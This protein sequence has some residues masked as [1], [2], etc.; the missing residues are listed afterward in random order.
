MALS[1]SIIRL[2][3]LDRIR[4]KIRGDVTLGIHDR[5]LF[6]EFVVSHDVVVWS[7]RGGN[8][9]YERMAGTFIGQLQT[10][11][12]YA[13][14][15]EPGLVCRVVLFRVVPGLEPLLMPLSRTRAPGLGSHA[16]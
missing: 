8:E 3:M 16:A 14:M 4:T 2:A 9:E 12:C 11:L 10:F 5:E 1:D 6:R 13:T 15:L 7:S